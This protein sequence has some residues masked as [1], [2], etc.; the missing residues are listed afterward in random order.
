MR[1]NDDEVERER[2]QKLAQSQSV[3]SIL[4]AQ[5]RGYNGFA[6]RHVTVILRTLFRNGVA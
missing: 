1:E 3:K 5:S 6:S 2:G 4:S